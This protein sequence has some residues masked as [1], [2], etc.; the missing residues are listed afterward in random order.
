MKISEM[1]QTIQDDTVVLEQE[2]AVDS[3]KIK[4]MV[5]QRIHNSLPAPKQ[6]HPFRK[7]VALAVA[8]AM[9]LSLGTTALAVS[10]GRSIAEL[11]RNCSN[12]T[13]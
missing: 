6:N 5:R 11:F 8:A 4:N 7:F 1:M 10:Q 12:R 13:N 3:E 9:V 2:E